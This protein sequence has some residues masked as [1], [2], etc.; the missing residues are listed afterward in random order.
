M[1]RIKLDLGWGEKGGR[2]VGR[3]AAGGA[4]TQLRAQGKGFELTVFLIDVCVGH[5]LLEALIG[6][7]ARCDTRLRTSARLAGATSQE[8]HSP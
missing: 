6:R 2:R 4:R 1:G 3:G 8:Q 7:R 5:S